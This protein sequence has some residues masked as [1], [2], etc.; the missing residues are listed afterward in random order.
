MTCQNQ[1]NSNNHMTLYILSIISH[2]LDAFGLAFHLGD[3][4]SESQ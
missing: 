4:G 2:L 3:E 1:W